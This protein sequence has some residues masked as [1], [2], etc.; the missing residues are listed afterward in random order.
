MHN[1]AS[2]C[3]IIK[4]ESPGKTLSSPT[5]AAEIIFKLRED[6]KDGVEMEMMMMIE[7]KKL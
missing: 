7:R 5:P 1:V 3:L 2:W 4:N 6:I